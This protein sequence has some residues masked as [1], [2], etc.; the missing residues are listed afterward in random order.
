MMTPTNF[1]IREYVP[2][3]VY[4]RFG[5]SSIWFIDPRI[6]LIKQYFETHLTHKCFVNNWAQGGDLNESGFRVPHSLTGAQFSQ[7]KFGRATDIHFL[8]ITIQEVGRFVIDH[9]SDLSAL[10]ATTVEDIT[11]TPTWLHIDTRWTGLEKMLTVKPSGV[12]NPLPSA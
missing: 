4:K 6:V 7:H 1:D 11:K 3:E 9:W 8:G 2:K 5:A 12:T 10:G